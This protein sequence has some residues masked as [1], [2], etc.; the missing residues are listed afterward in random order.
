[1]II[2]YAHD[3]VKAVSNIDEVL[4]IALTCDG[5]VY[6]GGD[7]VPGGGIARHRQVSHRVSA[8]EIRL[9][10]H[11]AQRV[12]LRVLI[13]TDVARRCLDA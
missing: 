6:Q 4:P 11:R 3:W 12:D 13:G 9:I 10:T 1:M 8:L 7:W 5:E 2:A